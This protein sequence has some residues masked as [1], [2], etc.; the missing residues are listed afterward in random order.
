[1]R[2]DLTPL[3]TWNTHT[4]FTSLVCEFQTPTAEAN[5]VTVWD[6]RVRRDHPEEHVIDLN[7]E[8]LEYY[9]TDI[10]K[11]LKGA[12]ITVFLRY[13]IMTTVGQYYADK[14]QVNSFKVPDRYFGESN[15]KYRPGPK[16]RE[17]NY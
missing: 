17:S 8:Y 4:V 7:E 5:A 11:K 10:N 3:M 15:R 12:K 6:Q 1:M 9:L 13:E 14:I 2:V 16:G